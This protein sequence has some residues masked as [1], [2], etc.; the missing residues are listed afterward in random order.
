MSWGRLINTASDY[1]LEDR[2]TGVRTQAQAEDFSS[3]LSVRPVLRPTQSPIQLISEILSLWVKCG[4]GVTLTTPIK[5]G[6]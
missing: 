6:G 4:R 3:S 5:Y 2:A 1:R